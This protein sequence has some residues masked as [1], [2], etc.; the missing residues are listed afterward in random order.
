MHSTETK[1]KFV[2]LRAAG[3]SFGDISEELNVSKRTLIRNGDIFGRDGAPSPSAIQPDKT[4]QN[5]TICRKHRN[6]TPQYQ[7]LT[8]TGIEV[9]RFSGSPQRLVLC[10]PRRENLNSLK[11]GQLE[12]Q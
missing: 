3:K 4:E 7:R 6:S 10:N 5:R 9:V 1:D 8:T 12:A 11:K 2:E